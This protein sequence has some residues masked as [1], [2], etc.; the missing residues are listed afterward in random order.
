MILVF[1]FS[2]DDTPIKSNKSIK[3]L[4][5]IIKSTYIIIYH[6]LLD[7]KIFKSKKMSKKK[8]DFNILNFI[9]P[10]RNTGAKPL[11]LVAALPMALPFKST[12][13]NTLFSEAK[14]PLSCQFVLE[15]L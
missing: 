6:H 11:L 13:Q 9:Y 15:L 4:K 10:I 12:H 1:L 8:Q 3:K 7:Y 5:I 14:L 2:K